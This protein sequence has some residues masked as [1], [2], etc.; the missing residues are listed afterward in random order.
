MEIEYDQKMFKERTEGFLMH[1]TSKKGR[2]LRYSEFS[3][4]WS[5]EYFFSY[6]ANIDKIQYQNYKISTQ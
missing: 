5:H 2:L 1:P 3:S 6:F 4:K